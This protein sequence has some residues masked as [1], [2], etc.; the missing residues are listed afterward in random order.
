M[1]PAPT[2]PTEQRTAEAETQDD[3]VVS[4]V[5]KAKYGF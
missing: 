3:L 4:T 1:Y 5:L 2:R